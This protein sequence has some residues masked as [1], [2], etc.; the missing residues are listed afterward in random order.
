MTSDEIKL[1]I[2]EASKKI[3]PDRLKVELVNAGLAFSTIEKIMRGTYHSEMKAPMI[4]ALKNVL[5]KIA[6]EKAS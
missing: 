1:A 4:F 5:T 6:S 2:K 3:G